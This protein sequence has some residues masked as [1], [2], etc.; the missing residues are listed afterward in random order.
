MLFNS[1]DYLVFFPLVF[2]AHHALPP[3]F[4]WAALL[5][6]S[7]V[8]YLSWKPGYALL[9]L[10]TTAASYGI[11][12]RMGKIDGS[13][14]RKALL[15]VGIGINLALLFVYKYLDFIASA[16]TDL[17]GVFEVELDI[18][19]LDLLLPVGI[20][21]FTFKVVSYL[22][23]VYR[24]EQEPERHPG[25]YALYVA[26]FPQLLAG[27]IERAGRLLGQLRAPRPFDYRMAVGGLQLIG[28]GLFKKIVIADRL[29]VLVDRVYDSPGTH[30]GLPVALATVAFTFQIYCDFSG[31]SDIAIGSAEL[32]GIKTMENFR[33]PYHAGSLAE[34]WRRWHISLSTWF[35]DYVYIPLG[36]NRVVKWR[37]YYNL[38]ITFLISGLWHG[39]AWT[40][41]IWGALHGLYLCVEV[42]TASVRARALR[43]LRLDRVPLVR[44]G[45]GI[46]ATF[47]LVAFAWLFFRA[48]G[49]T[50]AMTLV[51][52]MLRDGASYVDIAGLKELISERGLG[53][54]WYGV[55]VAVAGICLME[56][57]QLLQ[58]RGSVRELLARQPW[59][60]RWPAYVLLV[61]AI[62]LL[63][64]FTEQKFI[65]F[66]F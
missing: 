2:V 5:A 35:R 15:L 58:T 9:L 40:F 4:R 63:G 56:G 29:A 60:V 52:A 13:K 49:L 11:A 62:L 32:L 19:R 18:P 22:V 20:S 8:F 30:E 54:G 1:V 53:L 36:G 47:A 26:F 17:L 14:Q 21:F 28:W 57:V 33:R 59:F 44:R 10:L 41:V 27:P 3:R 64:R 24:G 37:W 38:M 23:D 16:L 25:Y 12:M 7:Y 45:L 65:Y 61:Q 31:Y 50:D 34:F 42:A 51:A 48:N 66:E 43:A 6:G 55:I 39:A 46:G